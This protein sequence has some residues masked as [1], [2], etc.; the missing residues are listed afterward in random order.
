V[1]DEA[2]D[3]LLAYLDVADAAIDPHSADQ[4]LLPLA[5]AE[6][7]SVLTVSEATEHLRTNAATLS[8]FLDRPIAISESVEDQPA[9]VVVG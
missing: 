4:L 6:G 8:A 1:A 7:R 2:V 3:E 9:R 5:L